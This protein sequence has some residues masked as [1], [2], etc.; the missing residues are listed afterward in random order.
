MI[1][2]QLSKYSEISSASLPQIKIVEQNQV[3]LTFLKIGESWLSVLIEFLL[4]KEKL[5]PEDFVPS[6]YPANR[7]STEIRQILPVVLML[8]LTASV[9]TAATILHTCC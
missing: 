7:Q 6:S 5:V 2:L 9:Y 8:L 4:K 3:M 1:A